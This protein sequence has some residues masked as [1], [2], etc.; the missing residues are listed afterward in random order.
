MANGFGGGIVIVSILLQMVSQ[1]GDK[2]EFLKY[3][4]PLTLLD[5]TGILK[6][7]NEAYMLIALLYGLAIIINIIAINIFCKKDLSI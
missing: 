6:G 1:V 3:C 2:F 4:T 7:T 5:V